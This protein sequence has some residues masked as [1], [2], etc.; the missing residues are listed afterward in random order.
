MTLNEIAYSIKNRLEGFIPSDDSVLD[1]EYMYSRVNVAR[2]ALIRML[3]DKKMSL[4]DDFYQKICCLEIQCE[5]TIC[6]NIELSR[7]YYVNVPDT[8]SVAQ[9]IKYFG[10]VDIARAFTYVSNTGFINNHA[11]QISSKIPYYTFINGK[12]YVKNLP[13]ADMKYLCMIAILDNPLDGKCITRSADDPYPLPQIYVQQIEEMVMQ[14]LMPSMMI[15]PDNANDASNDARSNPL[16]YKIQP[17][18]R[19]K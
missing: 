12:A 5:T 14:E 11:S 17:I 8:V 16:N 13:T 19:R 15:F 10:D 4:D 6:D 9:G 1:I 18:K 7:A 3:V 2:G